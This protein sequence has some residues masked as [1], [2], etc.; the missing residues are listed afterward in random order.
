MRLIDARTGIETLDRTV[1]LRLL[2]SHTVGRIAAVSGGRPIVL[3]INYAM[4]DEAV[5]F[6][7]A[8]GTKLSAAVRGSLVAF[9]IDHTD[10]IWQSGWSVMVSGT[11]EEVIDPTV[12][13]RLE[14]LPLRTWAPGAKDHWVRIAPEGL[15]GRRI[16]GIAASQAEDSSGL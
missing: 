13:E 10:P 14:Q 15:T 4:D 16:V 12:L 6:R 9:E 8:A 1:C 5:V 7:T 2:R 3:P 11:A